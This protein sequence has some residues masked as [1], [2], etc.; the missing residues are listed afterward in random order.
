MR[1]VDWHDG[2]VRLVDQR[3]LPW[4]VKQLDFDDYRDVAQA[5]T[6]QAVLGGSSIA[7]AAAFGMALAAQQSAATEVAQLLEYVEIAGVIMKKALPDNRRLECA[8][9]RL[10]TRAYAPDYATTAAIQGA[11]LDDAQQMAGGIVQANRAMA[12]HGAALLRGGDTVLHHGHTGGLSAV[13]YGTALGMIRAFHERGRLLRVLQTEGRPDLLGARLAAWELA[14]MG[15]MFEIIADAAAAFYMKEGEVS[16]VLVG[17]ERIALNGD[18][19]GAPGAFMLA[20]LAHEHH[21]P[22]Y[23]IAPCT[24]VDQGL[25]S[26][27]QIGPENGPPEA[28]RRLGNQPLVPDDFPARNLTHDV[29]PARFIT[30][31]ITENGI[32]SPPYLPNLSAAVTAHHSPPRA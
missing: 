23:V 15:V 18:A 7:A 1:Y 26:G 28:L 24:S 20:V 11:L 9:D 8:V 21:I 13:A 4:D 27:D 31:I 29:T 3:A 22:F 6:D 25:M 10:M 2:R 12:E 17:A 19:V 5:I 16:A 30:V 14:R 32:V